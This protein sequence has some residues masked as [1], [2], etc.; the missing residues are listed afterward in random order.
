MMCL[1][2]SGNCAKPILWYCA[3]RVRRH[4]NGNI[5]DAQC[6]DTIEI[7]IDR[8]IAEAALIFLRWLIKTTLCIGRHEQDDTYTRIAPGLNYRLRHRI[9]IIVGPSARLMMYIV[10]FTH[11]GI[12]SP[13]HLTIGSQSFFIQCVRV[14]VLR[15]SIHGAPPCPE[16]VLSGE[17][18][19]GMSTECTL[20]DVAVGVDKAR[21]Q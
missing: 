12:A 2:I 5:S 17:R 21:E 16:G 7:S 14:Q 19:M 20:K 1:A 13:Q 11:A 15:L 8:D 10:K 6:L 9:G 4:S 3:H 18:A